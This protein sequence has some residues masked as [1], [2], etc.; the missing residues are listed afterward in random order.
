VLVSPRNGDTVDTDADRKVISR[1][2]ALRQNVKKFNGDVVAELY[3]ER[4]E[5]M[6]K[7]ILSTTKAKSVKTVNPERLLFRFMAQAIRI[8]GMAQVIADLMGSDPAT[9]F[10][11]RTV[12][13]V[14]PKLVGVRYSDLRATS[15][16]GCIIAG[17]FTEDDQAILTSPGMNKGPI[18]TARTNLL[19]LGLPNVKKRGP[20][21]PDIP[22]SLT[23]GMTDR[24][25]QL[26]TAKKAKPEKFLIC[27]WRPGM[28]S[29]LKE[30]DKIVHR[31]SKLVILDDDAPEKVNL[32]LKNLSVS[33]I[34]KRPDVYENLEGV[35]SRQHFD[36]V[37]LLG[38]ALGI[39]NDVSAM[40]SDEDSKALATYVYVSDLLEKSQF[41][42]RPTMVTIE[43]NNEDVSEI[44]REEA[45][46]TS[47]ILPLNLG[48]KIAAQTM[49]DSKLHNVWS[50]L[51]EQNGKEVYLVPAEQYL[52]AGSERK[53]FGSMADDAA[54]EK[55]DT[56][57]GYIVKG[58][59]PNINPTGKE[60]TTSRTW[61][62][63]DLIIVVSHGKY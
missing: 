8:P 51:L 16:N 62:K 20:L 26:S 58:H 38:S 49:R 39:D 31:G 22:R 4:D 44:A 52:D 21:N 45:K 15:I 61:L 24:A 33:C 55:D 29:M 37:V 7:R 63:G 46:P 34:V 53:S 43:F 9:I 35:L 11:A 48:A 42:D 10:H 27:G 5:E 3:S 28:D 32:K 1:A 2:L 54:R 23:E 40:G 17:Y 57:L 41:S 30:L 18:L 47:V 25:I 14:S 19:L 50:E 13:D 6:V 56:I 59:E 60:R 12:G 36:S